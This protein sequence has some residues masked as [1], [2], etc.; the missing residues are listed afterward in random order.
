MAQ[1]V[2]N[3]TSI[4]EDVSSSPGLAQWV[5][6]PAL[7]QAAVWAADVARIPS[8][9]CGCGARWA[10]PAPIQPLGWELSNAAGVAVKRKRRKKKPVSLHQRFLR[11]LIRLFFF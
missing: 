3:L 8:G 11:L 6:D 7:P 9:C 4:R 1:Q 10:A 2:K 5:G